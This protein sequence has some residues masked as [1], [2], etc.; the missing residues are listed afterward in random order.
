M[1]NNND[2]RMSCCRATDQ[3]LP[4]MVRPVNQELGTTMYDPDQA[5]RHGTLF[6][7]LWKPLGNRELPVADCPCDEKQSKA[8]ALWEL[9]L[10][11]DTHPDDACAMRLLAE[12]H[13]QT[14]QPNYATTFLPLAQTEGTRTGRCC[15]RDRETTCCNEQRNSCNER[16]TCCNERTTTC[17]RDTTCCNERTTCPRETTCCTE[18]TTC[19]RD[20]TCCTERTTTCCNERTTTCPRDTTCCNE[21]TTTCPRETTCC[22]ER[23]TCP[24]DT[25]CCNER[26]TC[27]R[28][29]T[30]CTERTTCPR[31]TTCCTERTT[32]P[33]ASD[34]ITCPR[35]TTV[36]CNERT[37]CPRG[38]IACTCTETTRARGADFAWLDNPWPWEDNRC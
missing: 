30:C 20:T 14:P 8:F 18:R 26:T 21:R 3:S 34:G 10:Y 22:T 12:L 38:R 2:Q 36:C 29:T 13:D 5:L 9:R 24:R 1:T 37:A 11:L 31:D 15:N 17:P 23:T 6:P 19:P 27:P 4:A 28:D 7:E 35:E 33:R 32:C 16:T 25:T